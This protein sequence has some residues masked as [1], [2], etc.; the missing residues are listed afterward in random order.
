MNK[1]LLGIALI[2]IVLAGGAIVWNR[3]QDND[4]A[5]ED[6]AAEVTPVTNDISYQGVEGESALTLLKSTH[7]VETQSYSFGEMVVS[8]D[9]QAATDGVNFWEFLVN[10]QQ[11]TTGAGDYI[12]KAN[13]QIVWKL[14]NIDAQ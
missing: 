13:D 10:G 9:G 1:R 5:T 2:V 12:T 14:S 6:V 11:A 8:I 7:S 3:N 4:T